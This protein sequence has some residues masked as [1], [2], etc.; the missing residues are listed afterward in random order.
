LSKKKRK[1]KKF[2]KPKNVYADPEDVKKYGT[3]GKNG[4]WPGCTQEFINRTEKRRAKDKA[5]KRSR[6]RNRRR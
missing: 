1:P 2:V 3:K 6:K 4:N 5:A